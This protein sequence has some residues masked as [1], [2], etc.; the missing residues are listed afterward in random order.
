[1]SHERDGFLREEYL[2]RVNRVQDYIEANLSEEFSLLKLSQIANFSVYHF[3]R[4]FSS[5]TGEPLFQYIQR[6]RLEKAAFLLL[7]DPKK[8][9]T[10]IAMECGFSNQ[11]SFARAF[12]K[13]F[14]TSASQLRM[15]LDNQKSK[16]CKAESNTGKV[17]SEILLYNSII[18]K[19][20]CRTGEI[21]TDIP[22]S[23]E[24]KNIPEMHVV[25][26]RYI[27]PYKKD[28]A[29]FERLFKKLYKWAKAREL[30]DFSQTKWL[31]LYHD[32]PELTDEHK[33]RI[34]VCMT[35]PETVETD[36]EIGKLTIPGGKY[37]I[38][39]FELGS[40]QYEDAWYAL[41]G[42]WLPES[43][44]Q[45]D[46]RLSFELYPNNDENNSEEKH[47]VDIHIPIKPL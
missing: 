1:M 16:N 43:G 18:R 27:G 28:A 21:R 19:K 10:Q 47:F 7:A 26:V 14:D 42:K 3:H 12:K 35:A 44:Y 30:I 17:S 4:I 24:V 45:P 31:T 23:V 37:A 15:E 9:V 36:G 39:H 22:F 13:Y 34:S 20:Q 41:G 25:Y 11:A 38:G 29:L 46:D 2:S 8:P 5:M 6:V 40:D 33:L 32:N